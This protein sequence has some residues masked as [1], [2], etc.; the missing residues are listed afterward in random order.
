MITVVSE[1]AAA[2]ERVWAVLADPHSYADW[3]VGTR[4][5]RAADETWPAPGAMLHHELAAGIEDSTTVLESDEG[6]RLVLRARARPAGIAEVVMTV[7]PNGDGSKVRMEEKAVSGP[8]SLI[9]EIVLA[10][11]VKARN[12]ESLRRLGELARSRPR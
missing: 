10:P 11:L 3:V 5:I 4:R 2:P 9:P 6:K 1:L 7:E 8:A 12:E